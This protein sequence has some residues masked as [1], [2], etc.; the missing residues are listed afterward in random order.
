VA[1]R[2][3]EPL[4]KIL[5]ESDSE[6]ISALRAAIELLAEGLSS[7]SGWQ[8]EARVGEVVGGLRG[9][10][11]RLT[12]LMADQARSVK[13]NTLAVIENSAVRLQ[14]AKSSKGG[15]ILDKILSFL[16]GGL[17]IVNLIRGVVG[18]TERG[19]GVVQVPTYARPTPLTIEMS[20]GLPGT[21]GGMQSPWYRL[22]G[23]V[24]NERRSLGVTIQVQALDSKSFLDHSDEI[25]RAVERA[26]LRSHRLRDVLLEL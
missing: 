21:T 8:G 13:E 11:A 4:G 23:D 22:S 25:A 17:P 7:R 1:E 3:S 5:P 16:G 12:E 6:A 26:L 2:W 24:G 20:T 14:E 10:L 19:G 15:S 9:E 18:S